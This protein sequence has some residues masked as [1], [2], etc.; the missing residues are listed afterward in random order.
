MRKQIILVLA[1]LLSTSI[2]QPSKSNPFNDSSPFNDFLS[3][4]ANGQIAQGYSLACQT[5]QRSL[6]SYRSKEGSDFNNF[7]ILPSNAGIEKYLKAK[8][9]SLRELYKSSVSISFTQTHSFF[10]WTKE[11]IIS[12][13]GSPII[14]NWIA[15]KITI[16][17]IEIP[18][19]SKEE[20]SIWGS[21]ILYVDNPLDFRNS[22]AMNTS[23][24]IPKV[25]YQVN[26]EDVRRLPIFAIV[27][28]CAKALIFSEYSLSCQAIQNSGLLLRSQTSTTCFGFSVTLLPTNQSLE[29]VLKEKNIAPDAFV[30]GYSGQKFARVHLGC[31][32]SREDYGNVD[33]TEYEYVPFEKWS[34]RMTYSNY[35]LKLTERLLGFSNT[36]F[37][38]TPVDAI[39]SKQL[40]GIAAQ[41]LPYPIQNYYKSHLS[42]DGQC[43]YFLLDKP[44]PF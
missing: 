14:L 11:M 41:L 6:V 42:C 39:H 27:D 4:C 15:N 35:S 5:V 33:S 9:A 25:S 2:A 28:Q 29:H 18:I 8:G 13:S 16:N 26:G 30:V 7:L 32:P 12:V 24:P 43:E 17:G 44:L 10:G 37:Y 1:I 19:V 40:N 36:R 38:P 22:K 23:F 21:Y 34:G 31:L 3:R 20:G